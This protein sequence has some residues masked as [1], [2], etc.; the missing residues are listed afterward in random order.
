MLI[1]KFFV[2]IIQAFKLFTFYWTTK[3]FSKLIFGNLVMW[4]EVEQSICLEFL[5][6]F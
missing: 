6:S 4:K 3:Y 1:L 5:L 2:N